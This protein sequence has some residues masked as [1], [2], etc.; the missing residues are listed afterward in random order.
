MLFRS[1]TSVTTALEID[2]TAAPVSTTAPASITAWWPW[3]NSKSLRKPI[4][5]SKYSNNDNAVVRFGDLHGEVNV[6]PAGADDDEYIFAELDT[7]L[8][9][10]DVIR[11]LPGSGAILSFSD[12]TTF[13]MKPDSIIVL[14]IAS[15]QDSKIG[16]VAGNIWVNLKKMVEDG[17]MEVE[18]AQGVAG[19]KGTILAASVTQAGDEYYLFTGSAKITSKTNDKT[20]TLRPGQKALVNQNGDI[21]ASKFD[22]ES[23]AEE[24]GIALSVLKD[25]G[26]QGK[27]IGWL[28]W[29][30]TLLLLVTVFVAIL[31]LVRKKK[32]ANVVPATVVLPNAQP[33]NGFQPQPSSSY[34]PYCGQSVDRD[35]P[36]CGHCGKPL[37]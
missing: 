21:E 8:K 34:C 17:S 26:Y 4:E 23:K 12:M 6:K 7:P 31:L 20:I 16:L 22:I 2:T 11:T 24:F 1:K 19:I 28:L 32:R 14:D 30:V 18:M 3:T 5:P 37:K 33:S 29:V 35:A 13:V 25:D 15:E 27:S 9:H 36:F 10:G